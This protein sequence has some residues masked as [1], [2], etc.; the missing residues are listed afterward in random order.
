MFIHSF[1]VFVV[2]S[3]ETT[4]GNR[5]SELRQSTVTGSCHW[6]LMLH[7][8]HTHTQHRTF[9]FMLYFKLNLTEVYM[10]IRKQQLLPGVCVCV[11]LFC[12]NPNLGQRQFVWS[13]DALCVWTVL[14]I[15]EVIEYLESVIDHTQS[16]T[17]F[18]CMTGAVIDL[19]H[20]VRIWA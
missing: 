4:S 12:R 8:T 16:R 2:F 3:H 7:H 11:C 13:S 10:L 6:G 15:D 17:L 5:R 18:N 14:L 19:V 1:R 20:P 9:K